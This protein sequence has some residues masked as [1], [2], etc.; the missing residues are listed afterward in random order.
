MIPKPPK[1]REELGLS[2]PIFL[3]MRGSN[4]YH[5]A[6]DPGLYENLISVGEAV[7]E[8]D[9]VGL[10]HNM[11]HPSAAAIE[12]LARQSG[13]VGVMRGFPRVN[14]GDLV[15]VIGKAYGSIEDLPE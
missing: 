9:G 1:T 15:A 11:D 4:S 12:V 14:I 5:Q 6:M 3:D 7:Y 10:I 8:G 2:A 13:I